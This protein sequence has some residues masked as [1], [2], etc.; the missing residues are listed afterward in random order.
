MAGSVANF[1][2]LLGQDGVVGV[3]TGASVAAGGCLSIA[4]L[5]AV[6]GR[7]ALV[8]AVILG[9]PGTMPVQTALLAGKALVDAAG[10]AVK[11]T[12]VLPAGTAIAT[13]AVPWAHTVTAV[14][15][16]DARLPAWGGLPIV[17]RFQPARLGHSLPRGASIGTLTVSV[18]GR[19]VQVPVGVS[20]AIPAAP[21]S[22]RLRRAP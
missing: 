5:R 14:T 19:Q 13:V 10:S 12:T 1:N 18:N 6:G 16:A 9:Q 4:A 22:W 20:R 17:L 3:K 15:A 7:P 11:T 21:L 2:S 8:Y